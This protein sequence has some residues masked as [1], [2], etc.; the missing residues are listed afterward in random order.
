MTLK[1]DRAG[2]HDDMSKRPGLQAFVEALETHDERGGS[3]LDAVVTA[4]A[5][6]I[7]EIESRL[8]MLENGGRWDSDAEEPLPPL[9]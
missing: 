7:H 9:D 5:R 8:I 6:A 4:T 2:F 1:I 3:D